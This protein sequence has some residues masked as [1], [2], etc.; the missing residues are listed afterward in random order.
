[1]KAHIASMPN[2]RAHSLE[3]SRQ[4]HDRSGWDDLLHG[5][6]P[7]SGQRYVSSEREAPSKDRAS[8]VRHAQCAQGRKLDAIAK[9]ING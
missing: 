9:K 8:L 6:K 7:P 1:M 4:V 5:T 2:T 3:T